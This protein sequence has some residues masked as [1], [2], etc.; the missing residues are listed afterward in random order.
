MK[1]SEELDKLLEFVEEQRRNPELRH[2]GF[3]TDRE[4]QLYEALDE[5]RRE[6]RHCVQNCK[7]LL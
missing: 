7:N 4:S 2:G 3:K 1:I 5:L 6:V